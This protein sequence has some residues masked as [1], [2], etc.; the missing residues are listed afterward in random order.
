MKKYMKWLAVVAIGLTVA[1]TVLADPILYEWD[2]D[3]DSGDYDDYANWISS[4]SGYPDDDND[5]AVIQGKINNPREIHLIDECILDLTLSKKINFDS[6]DQ[7]GNTLSIE[8]ELTINGAA[9]N[10]TEIVL[11]ST[12]TIQTTASCP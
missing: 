8:G 10:D 2:T 11:S 6:Q 5:Q 1:F 3:V 7:G 4:G 9:N 12:T